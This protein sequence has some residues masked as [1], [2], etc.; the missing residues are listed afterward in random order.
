MKLRQ[1]ADGEMPTQEEMDEMIKGFMEEEERR[2][3]AAG[4]KKEK[5]EGHDEL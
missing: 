4:E 1:G 5:K 3:E 2:A